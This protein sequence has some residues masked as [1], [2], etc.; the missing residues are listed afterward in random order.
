MATGLLGVLGLAALGGVTPADTSSDNSA[1]AASSTSDD[2][3]T[4]SEESSRSLTRTGTE[5]A[6]T[7][8][9]AK[10]APKTEQKSEVQTEAQKAADK[11]AADKKAA[12]KKAADKKAVEQKAA[13]KLKV[14]GQAGWL[15]DR[16]AKNAATIVKVAKEMGMNERAQVIAL[17][18]ALQES[19]LYNLASGVIDESRTYPNE[20]VGWDHDSVGLFQQRPSSGWGSVQD[21]MDPNYQTKAFLSALK[22]VG[23]WQDLPVTIA[24]QTVQVS[25]FPDAYAK[26]ESR[27]T[28]IVSALR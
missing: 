14:V 21:L 28:A 25:A 9:G 18:T 7:A 11:K 20:G 27:A 15:D 13:E 8:P 2:R 17:S 6:A 3:S 19:N 23:N 1:K 22:G 12:D 5:Q 4:A 10:A 16:Q 24:A 26:H